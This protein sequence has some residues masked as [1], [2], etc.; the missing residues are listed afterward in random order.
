[1]ITCMCPHIYSDIYFQYTVSDITHTHMDSIGHI[2][3]IFNIAMQNGPFI[4]DLPIGNGLGVTYHLDSCVPRRGFYKVQYRA[5]APC[6]WG[7]WFLFWKRRM[8]QIH[9]KIYELSQIAI[10]QS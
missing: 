2:L 6:V 4:V 3:W 1:M 7:G 5:S 8:L 10:F 9:G